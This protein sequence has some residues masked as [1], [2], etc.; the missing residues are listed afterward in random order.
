MVVLL[1]TGSFEGYAAF[2]LAG[3]WE[4]NR[5]PLAPLYIYIYTSEI[6]KKVNVS[7]K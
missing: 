2:L 1:Y 5:G 6:S 4:L 3:T 7:N